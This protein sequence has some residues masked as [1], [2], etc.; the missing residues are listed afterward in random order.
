ML[1]RIFVFVMLLVVL[2]STGA[3]IV[4]AD[5]FATVRGIVHD[6]QHRPIAGAKV[7]LA[8][9]TSSFSLTAT[10]DQDGAFTFNPVPL[11]DYKVTVSQTGFA[12]TSET[13]TVASASSPILHFPLNIATV[14]QAATVSTSAATANLQSV[15]PTTLVDRTDIAE[16]PGADRTNS[17]AMIT[18][19]VPAAYVTHD[20]LHMRGGHQVDWLIDG[21]PIPN[22]NIATNLGPVIDPKDVDYL[23][24]LR[25]SYD[26]GYGDRTYGIFNVV[27]RN[28]FERD[29]EA[30]LVTSFGNWDQTNDQLNLGGHTERFA[31]YASLNGNRSNYGLQT[32]IG[33]VFHNAENGGGAFLSLIFNADPKNQLRLVAS[34][35]G[36]Y[37]QIPYDPEPNASFDSSQLRDAERESDAYL[38]FT[39]THTFNPNLLL[40]VS[41]FYHYNKAD[42][43]GGPDDSPVITDVNQSANYAGVQAAMNATIARNDVQFG[44]YGFAQHQNNYF[45]NTFTDG[46]PND[47]PSS[48]ALTGALWEEFITDKFRATSWLT[49]IAGLRESHFDSPA[50]PN[51]AAVVENATDPR[52]G[53]AVRIPRVNWV[54]HAFYGD[55]YQAP[56][57][58]TATGP[59]I[60]LAGNAGLAFAPIHGERDEEHQFG[61]TIPLRK[62]TLDADTFQTRAKNWLD[63]S[64]IGESN[65]FWPL[66]WDGALIQAWE[67]T[68]ASPRLWN[69]GQFHLAYSNQI[70]RAR[71]PFTGGLVC[72]DP[73][74]PECEPPPAYAPVDHDQRNTLNVGFNATLPWHAFAAT[75]VYYGSGFTNG[76]PQP[77]T[78]YP[79]D[80]LPAHTTFD[81][82][83]GKNFGEKYSISVS[84]LNVTNRRVLLD[85]SLTFG[86]FHFNDPR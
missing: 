3:A 83:L 70:A 24:V 22:T 53:L 1:R 77:G 39:W 42:Y 46:T 86:G 58:V 10:T 33:Q 16:T 26:A 8:S 19:Y 78:Q 73:A 36:D 54:F 38:A 75:N 56:P 27:P 74:D 65:L 79:S 40:N 47:A 15:T 23:E 45:S 64:N 9:A 12:T 59:L 48:G 44:T 68:L 2:V 29:D 32:P 25:G 18:D 11:G 71:G 14:N 5:I 61:A 17:L 43:A 28:G 41:P 51:Q 20:M 31:Y 60:S 63:H 4:R 82:S 7:V 37:Y 69:R 6:P 30:E 72:A 80:Y 85:N 55:F 62:W 66:T 84:D 52:F 50:L 21:V 57:L 67:L 13:L 35:R 76:D 34:M 49:V 81:L